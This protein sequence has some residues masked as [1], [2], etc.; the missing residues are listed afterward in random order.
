[1]KLVATVQGESGLHFGN[2][3]AAGPFFAFS[4]LLIFFV[5]Q[6]GKIRQATKKSRPKK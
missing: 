4:L 1:V 3:Y 2:R 5:A 6:R